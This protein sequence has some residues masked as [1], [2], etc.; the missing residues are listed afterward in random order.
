[1]KRVNWHE[2][3]WVGTEFC[4]ICVLERVSQSAKKV[5]EAHYPRWNQRPVLQDLQLPPD[6]HTL[7]E[8]DLSCI[9]HT[10]CIP[11]IIPKMPSSGT[12][13]VLTDVRNL[14]QKGQAPG[15]QVLPHAPDGCQAG[16]TWRS[17]QR[18]GRKPG[19][20]TSLYNLLSV[21]GAEEANVAKYRPH[22]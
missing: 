11:R 6:T 13:A 16:S 14:V 7:V 21:G 15:T 22:I 10:A 12:V 1:M 2:L 8:D 9:L 19:I 4:I 20:P 3:S 18:I 5:G 17:T